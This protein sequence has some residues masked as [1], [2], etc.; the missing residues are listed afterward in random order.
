[1]ER[2]FMRFN[3][4]NITLIVLCLLVFS[5]FDT[6]AMP[7]TATHTVCPSGCA[8]NSVQDAIN[9]ASSGDIIEISA[10]TYTESISINKDL[11]INGGGVNQTILQAATSKGMASDRVVTIESGAAVTISGMTI[12][13]GN[14][15]GSGI[16]EYGGGI[17][18]QG[19]LI[20]N[21]VRIRE[22]DAVSRGG[23]VACVD[24]N[25][26][27]TGVSITENTSS[28]WGGGMY[29]EGSTVTFSRSL[30]ADNS[31]NS[32]GGGIYM[33][34]VSCSKTS[35]LNFTNST[36]SGNITTNG[37][38]RGGGAYLICGGST[39]NLYNSTVSNNRAQ[40]AGAGVIASWYSQLNIYSSII[41][42]NVGPQEC[43]ADSNA[44]V[45][46][47]GYAIVEDGTCLSDASSIS[48]DPGLQP[49][50][51]NG[52]A[53]L[54]H[55][56][57]YN[58]MAIDAGDCGISGV[59]TDQRGESRSD[60]ACDVGAFEVQVSDHNKIRKDFSQNGTY[61]FGPTMAKLEITNVACLSGIEIT[62]VD[63]NH[64]NASG[65]LLTGRYW[66]IEPLGCSSGFNINLALPHNTIP[67]ANDKLCRYTGTAWDCA[68]DSFEQ[69]NNTIT[70][71]GV[72]QFSDWVTGDD[73]SPT[74]IGISVVRGS[75]FRTVLPMFV[76]LVL[77]SVGWLVANK[78]RTPR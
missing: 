26:Q 29:V 32:N 16:S 71:N 65:N 70:R 2:N 34:D 44:S 23:G 8:F 57:A 76:V 64:P 58:S 56:L 3:L 55:A 42:D 1:M 43:I 52:G 69:S 67:D 14:A 40:T 66:I 21:N 41:A 77:G 62:R 10:G 18:N 78:V 51:D 22:N 54:T 74:A 48:G 9:S 50:A 46:D 19:T 39:L 11:T 47:L 75:S 30:L 63:N 5:V 53:T 6:S 38:S 36:L 24:G 33:G 25:C 60:W 68:A 35:A 7:L 72:T 45:N 37:T 15:S 12:R 13:F 59:I 17:L 4:L 31:A 27:F 49:L 28:N 73:V 20:A 61:T